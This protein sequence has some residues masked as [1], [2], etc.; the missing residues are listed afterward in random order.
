MLASPYYIMELNQRGYLYDD[1]F[2]RYAKG[3]QY[4][5]KEEYITMIKYPEGLYNLKKI[6]SKGFVEV[7][8]NPIQ[9]EQFVKHCE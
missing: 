9:A 8:K 4:L 1:N 7:M 6:T 2:Q 3:L 5:F